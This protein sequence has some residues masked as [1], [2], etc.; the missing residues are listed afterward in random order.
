MFELLVL[1]RPPP[2]SVSSCVS[3]RYLGKWLG[4]NFSLR[5][6]CFYLLLLFYFLSWKFY[7]LA[8]SPRLLPKE[9]QALTASGCRWWGGSGPQED[10]ELG[11]GAKVCQAG[12]EQGKGIGGGLGDKV[13]DPGPGE[14][15]ASLAGCSVCKEI[16]LPVIKACLPWFWDS[17]VSEGFRCPGSD[18]TYSSLP[19]S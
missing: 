15:A 18:C 3:H 16:W 5:K 1:A 7:Q 10:L 8:G 17:S 9:P 13:W 11:P 12:R 6:L 14:S 2:P 4:S 19:A